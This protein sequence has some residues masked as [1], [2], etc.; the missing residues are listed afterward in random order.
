MPYLRFL[1]GMRRCNRF[2]APFLISLHNIVYR[3][4]FF[5]VVDIDKIVFQHMEGDLSDPRGKNNI[6]V[7]LDYY[8]NEVLPL[9]G[10]FLLEK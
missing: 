4:V 9:E 10:Y 8:F 7:M 2:N 3:C 6:Q 5:C 1:N